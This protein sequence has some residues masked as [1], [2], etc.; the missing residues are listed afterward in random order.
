MQRS[1]QLNWAS[2]THA[3][4]ELQSPCPNKFP[5]SYQADCVKRQDGYL[6]AVL[7]LKVSLLHVSF[8]YAHSSFDFPSATQ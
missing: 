2:S 6:E 3:R 8:I 4:E 5:F 1:P 7:F